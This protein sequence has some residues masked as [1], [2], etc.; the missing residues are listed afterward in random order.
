MYDP[1]FFCLLVLCLVYLFMN[2]C[3]LLLSQSTLL[4]FLIGQRLVSPNFQ[5]GVSLAPGSLPSVQL[6]PVPDVSL[7]H[8]QLL[9]FSL[10]ALLPA[11]SST[12]PLPVPCSGLKLSVAPPSSRTLVW[13]SKYVGGLLM[14]PAFTTSL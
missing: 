8:A 5:P 14:G 10:A 4:L 3:G 12:A 11:S 13:I 9:A 1:V 2:S 7:Y 6:I